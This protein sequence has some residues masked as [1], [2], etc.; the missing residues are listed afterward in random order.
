MRRV[1]E[2]V[3]QIREELDGAKNYAETYLELKAA[4][5]A[6]A[7]KYRDMANDELRH[8]DLIH[9]RAAEE[10]K[11]LQAVYTPPEDMAEQ[12]RASHRKYAEDAAW[13]KTMLNM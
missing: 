6:W 4:G 5:D 3:S 2:L 7:G 10:I 8:A 11:K 12:W 1:A 13:I 9:A